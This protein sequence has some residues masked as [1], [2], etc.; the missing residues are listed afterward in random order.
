[1]KIYLTPYHVLAVLAGALLTVASTSGVANS[2]EAG[3]SGAPRPNGSNESTCS[4]CHRGN[5]EYGE[6]VVTTE[7]LDENGVAVTDYTPGDTYTVNVTIA[8]EMGD[9]AG[10]GF[11]MAVV[12]DATS[13]TVGNYQN[14]EPGTGITILNPDTERREYAEQTRVSDS[15]VFT[16]EW[17]APASGTGE[18]TFYTVGNAVNGDGGNGIGDAGSREATTVALR[19]ARA[20]PVELTSFTGRAVKNSVNMSWT[21]A[22]EQDFSHFNVERAESDGDF[23]QIATVPGGGSGYQLTDREAAPGGKYLQTEYDRPGR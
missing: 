21:T 5:D 12:D 19:E 15:G 23:V 17:V 7:I 13:N 20:L 16:V 1:M 2:T 14:P 18:V 6:A 22:A 8:S 4:R 11:Q 10:Y 9:P 3:Y